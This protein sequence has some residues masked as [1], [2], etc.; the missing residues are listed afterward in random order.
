M[1]YTSLSTFRQNVQDELQTDLGIEM[2][3]GVPV[4][5]RSPD[6][7]AGFVRVSGITEDTADVN[8]TVVELTIEVFSQFVVQDGG[9]IDADLTAFEDWVEK[10]QRSLRD[11]TNS[12]GP[13]F[14]RITSFT[15]DYETMSLTATVAGWQDNIFF[16]GG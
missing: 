8:V 12:L 7:A 2:Q 13:W 3:A 9:D 1:T 5:D 15:P 14:V 11:K 10:V 6:R 16:T 4:G